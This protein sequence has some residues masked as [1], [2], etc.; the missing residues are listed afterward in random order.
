MR[1]IQHGPL[2]GAN[3][4]GV[5]LTGA[6]LAGADLRNKD[7]DAD[8][9][10]VTIDNRFTVNHIYAD[11][12][13][14]TDANMA[15]ANLLGIKYSPQ[16]PDDDGV[17]IGTFGLPRYFTCKLPDDL[18][19]ANLHR[20]N[21]FVKNTLSGK[22]LTGANLTDAGLYGADLTGAT[23]TS[24]NLTGADL[25]HATL[26][27]ADPLLTGATLTG[28]NLKHTNMLTDLVFNSEYG[29]IPDKESPKTTLT[30][31]ILIN[32][33]LHSAELT[34][35]VWTGA[36]LSGADLSEAYLWGADLTGATIANTNFASAFMGY[37]TMST[38]VDLP[39]KEMPG[40]VN[41]P[42]DESLN[43]RNYFTS[44]GTV[45]KDSNFFNTY[46]FRADL[47]GAQIEQSLFMNAYLRESDPVTRINTKYK[48][49]LCGFGQ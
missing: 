45:I 16:T 7:I 40:K 41:R 4:H 3:L 17:Y 26:T 39:N 33:D 32:A 24:A 5:D 29:L 20:C 23:L 13:F 30:G 2:K 49:C 21:F 46:L 6:N 38:G 15:G 18:T 14:L 36:D 19:G 9:T 11:S 10:I 25:E 12:T 44:D 43:L 42:P 28:A 34:G 27:G 31:T 48:L 8:S 37:V 22:D 35:T 1:L 47:R